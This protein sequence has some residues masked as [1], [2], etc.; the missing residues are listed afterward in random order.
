MNMKDIIEKIYNIDVIEKIK[1]GLVDNESKDIFDARIQYML[2]GDRDTFVESVE[3][4]LSN[5]VSW[6]LNAALKNRD[7]IIIYGS[8]YYG[9]YDKKVVELCGYKVDYFCDSY[10]YGHKVDGIEVISP[11]EVVEKY[12]NYLVIISSASYGW[13]MR[14]NLIQLGFLP[15]HIIFPKKFFIRE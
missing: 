13:D 4:Y 7:G 10:E 12:N 2:N 14:K 11:Q 6:E 9:I 8:G 3:P 1:S 15:E 5:I